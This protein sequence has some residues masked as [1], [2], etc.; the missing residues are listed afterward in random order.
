MWPVGWFFRRLGGIPVDRI[1]PHGLVQQLADQFKEDDEFII[2]MMPEGTRKKVK[3]LRTGFYHIA[4]KA[5]APILMA[6]FDFSK[7][8]VVIAEPFFTSDNEEKDL[9][10]IISFFAPIKGKYPGQG[11]SHL[12]ESLY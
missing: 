10:C 8:E 4:K 6:G 1:N 5:N 9:E 2:C 7:R 12:K 3:R 11:L